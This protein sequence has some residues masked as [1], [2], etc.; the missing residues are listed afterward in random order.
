MASFSTTAPPGRALFWAGIG[1]C[2]LGVALMAAQFG[3][4]VLVVPWY[5][6]AL[7]T[8]GALLLL[9]AIARRLSIV[10]VLA[11]LLVAALAGF[12]WYFIVTLMKLPTYEGSA[13]A[14]TPFPAFA[15]SLADGRPFTEADTRDGSR[16]VMVFFRG[17]W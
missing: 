1:V 16:R 13:Q 15:S 3:M 8:L 5:A 14:G 4:K 2:L 6:P 9:M 11:L 17:R 7:A 10:R 12:Q